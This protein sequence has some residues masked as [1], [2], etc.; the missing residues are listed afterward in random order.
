MTEVCVTLVISKPMSV[1]CPGTGGLEKVFRFTY[2]PSTDYRRAHTCT[3]TVVYINLGGTFRHNNDVK[4]I[5]KYTVMLK[6]LLN[7]ENNF[8]AMTKYI[9]NR[10][11]AYKQYRGEAFHGFRQ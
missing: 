11:Q 2:I 1:R 7:I 6:V 5:K 10:S 9:V 8:L 3:H 4:K